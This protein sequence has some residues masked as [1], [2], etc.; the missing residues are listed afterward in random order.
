METDLATQVH[1]ALHAAARSEAE[2]RE[3]RRAAG[4]LLATVRAKHGDPR[5]W[6]QWLKHAGIDDRGAEL[7]LQ[8]AAGGVPR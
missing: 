5:A 2:A 7:L 8:L 4:R 3:H 1:D 6:H